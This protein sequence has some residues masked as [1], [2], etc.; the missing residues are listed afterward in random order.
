M[1]VNVTM[2]VNLEPETDTRSHNSRQKPTE[3]EQNDSNV[4]LKS[5]V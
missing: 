2:R 5:N 3:Y 4:I 1:R